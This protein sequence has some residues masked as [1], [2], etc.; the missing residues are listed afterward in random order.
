[1]SNFFMRSKFNLR[2][3]KN[4]SE[5]LSILSK[6]LYGEKPFFGYNIL[7]IMLFIMIF[8]VLAIPMV[9]TNGF[10][11]ETLL[12][13]I[14]FIATIK[15]SKYLRNVHSIDQLNKIVILKSG[16]IGRLYEFIDVE[17]TAKHFVNQKKIKYIYFTFSENQIAAIGSDEGFS[18]L[19]N[20]HK[21]Y[22]AYQYL[23]TNRKSK[24]G[25]IDI[26]NTIDEI[27]LQENIAFAQKQY[28]KSQSKVSYYHEMYDLANKH[29]SKN[30]TIKGFER[31]KERI[32]NSD[33]KF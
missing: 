1:M 14:A 27:K 13:F 26:L 20:V 28:E 12:M 17:L 33:I 19:D 15:I 11:I 30:D 8:K 29:K 4:K 23:N 32:K 7:W 6:N 3:D 22:I 21:Y 10:L 16:R 25:L 24:N 18:R 31:Q 9:F 5:M 2:I